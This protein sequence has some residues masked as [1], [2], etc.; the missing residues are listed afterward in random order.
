MIMLLPLSAIA[1]GADPGVPAAEPG[2]PAAAD[3]GIELPEGNRPVPSGLFDHYSE[4]GFPEDSRGLLVTGEDPEGWMVEMEGERYGSLLY[5]QFANRQRD[6]VLFARRGPI[7]DTLPDGSEHPVPYG[8][9]AVRMNTV[10]VSEVEAVREPHFSDNVK[11]Y[12]HFPLTD[13]SLGGTVGLSG[14]TLDL[15]YVH[16]EQY[17]GYLRGG[18]SAFGPL[19]GRPYSTYLF[20]VHAGFGYRFPGPLT[21]ILGDNH[22]TISADMLVGLGEPEGSGYDNPV[23]LP[24]VMVEIERSYYTGSAARDPGSAARDPG[25]A[26]RDPGSA[27]RDPG[28]AGREDYREDPRPFNYRVGAAALHLGLHFDFRNRVETGLVVLSAGI[29]YRYNVIGPRIPEHTFKETR[30]VYLSEEYLAQKERE[31]QRR[32]ARIGRRSG[33]NDSP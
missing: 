14:I 13:F 33:D 23:F 21:N 27:A 7:S 29:T 4:E 3:G 18:I 31:R 25:S 17:V 20:P 12:R 19:W 32:E 8:Y 9:G 15:R 2:G 22:L 10:L 1:Q 28:S 16:A 6:A 26:A 11:E 30:E 24:G 5:A